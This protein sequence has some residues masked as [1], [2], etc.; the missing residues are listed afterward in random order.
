M[1][2]PVFN[3]SMSTVTSFETFFFSFVLQ[4]FVVKYVVHVE[5]KI[6]VVRVKLCFGFLHFF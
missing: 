4:L 6:Y 1:D 5:V 2:T 3:H